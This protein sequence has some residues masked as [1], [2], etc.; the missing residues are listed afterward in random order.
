MYF[1]ATRLIANAPALTAQGH[2]AQPFLSPSRNNAIESLIKEKQAESNRKKKRFKNSSRAIP[3]LSLSLSPFSSPFPNRLTRS[4][5]RFS[6]AVFLPPLRTFP[7]RSLRSPYGP[8]LSRD[9][10]RE[11]L[12]GTA[13]FSQ[14][15][16]HPLSSR[17]LSNDGQREREG[18]EEAVERGRAEKRRKTGWTPN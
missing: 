12:A 9:T 16:Q 14:F 5:L 10:A 6:P 2:A 1:T 7:L 13:R 18:A 17:A 11:R 4:T 8:L 3:F 15:P